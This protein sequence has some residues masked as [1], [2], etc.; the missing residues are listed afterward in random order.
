[1]TAASGRF[2]AEARALAADRRSQ[3]PE[4]LT[5][6]RLE[7]LERFENLGFP[8]TRDEEWRFTSVAPVT[9]SRFS[10]ARHGRSPRPAVDVSPWRLP[11]TDAAT[12]VFVNG[13]YVPAASDTA[14]LPAGFRVESLAAAVASSADGIEAYL[15]QFASANRNPFSV[16]NAA[17]LSEG[18]AVIVP[19]GAVLD[20]PIHLLFVSDPEAEPLMAHPRV[21]AV[22]GVNSEA[23]VI[24]SYVSSGA[25]RP[26]PARSFTNTVTEI[27][28]GDGAR[29][30]HYRI[31]RENAGSLHTSATY[32][33][34]GRNA[35]LTCH[36]ATLDGQLVRN[37]I[38]VVLDGEGAE[39]TLNG[40]YVSDGVRFVDNHTTI[41]HAQPHCASREVYKGILADRARAVFNG[42]IIVRPDAQQTDAKQTSK[43]LL[44]SEDAQIN[45]NPQLEIFANDVKC[46]HGAAVGQIDDD[47]IFYLRARGLDMAEARRMLVR[48][49]AAEV[50]NRIPL[51]PL[52]AGFDAEVLRRMPER[53]Q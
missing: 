16:L 53:I 32:A 43:A 17:F 2:A 5:R 7:A 24:E 49:F 42:K 29:L 31:Q 1:M 18:A 4:W 8:T 22:L 14:R 9:E 3:D 51:E 37:D 52:R 38:N 50:L 26:D 34:I 19:D 35:T 15:N 36:T 13:R 28:A 47:A 46:T 25:G 11:L 44:L 6:T 20:A 39:C 41:D 27:H 12:L 23:T 33:R 45:T 30:H 10:L 48:A 40:L 21:V